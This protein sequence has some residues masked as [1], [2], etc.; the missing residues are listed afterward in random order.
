MVS[1]GVPA[2]VKLLAEGKLENRKCLCILFYGEEVRGL[3]EIV[4]CVLVLSEDRLAL[5]DK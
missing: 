1:F 2:L 4:F 5:S 3:F